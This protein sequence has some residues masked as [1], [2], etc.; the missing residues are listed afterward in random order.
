MHAGV[1]ASNLGLGGQEGAIKVVM[2]AYACEP[3]R[4]SEPGVGWNWAVQAAQHGHEV[5]VLTRVNNRRDIEAEIRRQPVR[6]LHF[7]YLDLPRPFLWMKKRFGYH[8]LALYYYLWQI[9]LA[10]H[11]R[12]LHRSEQFDLAHHV[13]FVNDWA[14]AGLAALRIPFIWGPIGGS[15]HIWPKEIEPHLP[16]YARRHEAIRRWTIM[17]TRSL[18]PL[19]RLTGKRAAMILAYTTESLAG[20]RNTELARARAVTHIGLEHQDDDIVAEAPI[21]AA[22]LRIVTGGRLVH[23]K[24][25]D[26][27]IEGL[28]ESCEAGTKARLLVT[29]T[30]PYLPH[31]EALVR[32]LGV[33]DS[34]DFLGRLPTRSDVLDLLIGCHLYALPTLRDGPPVAILEAMAIGLPVLCLDHGAT[35]E[36]VPEDGGLKIPMHSREQVV[37]D[38]ATAITA[39]TGDRADLRERGLEARR[40][41]YA[42]HDWVRIGDEID[43]L[44]VELLGAA[45]N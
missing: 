42:V 33:A 15:T 23:W 32:R 16:D 2:G 19:R 24:G 44:Y 38:I 35:A 41:A 9:S 12:K 40:Y 17:T 1:T 36:L 8:G 20:L 4:G 43:T 6:G 13:T 14:P 11:A 10:A 45:G 37:S 30:G 5:H 26:L 21:D 22:E 29:G 18:D 7:H 34:V 28:A 31:M 39:A 3:H 27:L 25:F